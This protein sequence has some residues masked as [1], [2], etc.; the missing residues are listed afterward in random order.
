KHKIEYVANS[1]ATAS[2]AIP[3][4]CSDCEVEL[5]PGGAVRKKDGR[6]I[7]LAC[8]KRL[9][10]KQ[11]D[12]AQGDLFIEQHSLFNPRRRNVEGFTDSSGGFH[13]I[14]ASKDYNEFLAGDFEP[15]KRLTAKQ[16]R[17]LAADRA[18]EEAEVKRQ[19]A[20]SGGPRKTLAQFVR[21]Y[22]GIAP[23][24]MY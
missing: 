1:M 10:E 12:K 20:D 15:R 7:C 22:G 23:G 2:S 18:A 6:T 19:I 5:T 24:A 21:S 8:E 4:F 9:R 11:R 14:R 16:E 13:P 3:F 17:Q